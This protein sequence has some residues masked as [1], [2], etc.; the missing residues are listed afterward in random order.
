M[1]QN[2]EN[3]SFKLIWLSQLI[4]RIPDDRLSSNGHMLKI[5]HMYL[6]KNKS[7]YWSLTTLTMLSVNFKGIGTALATNVAKANTQY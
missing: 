4:S 3:T 2:S 7:G 1:F 5:F 6:V